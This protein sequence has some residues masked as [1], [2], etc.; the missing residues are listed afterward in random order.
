V[1]EKNHTVILG[2][3]EQVFTIISELVE[4]NSNQPDACIVIM[5]DKDKVEMEDE[6][7]EKV[8]GTGKTRVVCRSGNPIDMSDLNI[9]SLN[10]SKSIL[11]LS[12]ETENPD[13]E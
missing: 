10:T 3:S 6:I 12:P 13:A 7:R 9:V 5:G 8:G 1:I 4:A 11:V 2:W